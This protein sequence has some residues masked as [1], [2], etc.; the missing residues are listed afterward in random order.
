MNHKL[1]F[2]LIGSGTY[3]K[4]HAR[5]YKTDPR[6]TLKSLWSPT[7]SHREA[8]ASHFGCTA[9][10]NWNEIVEDSSINC[11]AIAT[12]DFAHTEYAVAALKAGKHVILEK[13]MALSAGECKKIIDARD[14]TSSKLMINYHNRWYPAFIA[15]R[16]AILSGRIGKPVS[17][18]FVL[19]DTISWVEDNMKWADG[20]GPEWFLMSHIADLAFWM[21][22]DNP[23]EIFAMS[24][25]GL[26]E[27]KGFKTR[28]LVKAIMRMKNGTVVHFESSWVLARNWRNPVNDMRVSVQCEQGR[29][30]IV[31]DYEN[32]TITSDSYKTPLIL[33]EQ[34]EVTPIQ[35]FITSV[36]QDKPVPVTGEEG[37]LTTKAIEAVVKSY[38]EKRIVLLDE[39]K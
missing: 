35:D 36:I 21:M 1:V 11:V 31:A 2:G 30:D 17:G 14:S 24:R 4:V 6:V 10:E 22:R 20:S 7:K 26:L 38:T 37:L 8:A 18:N 12:P 15:G 9:R 33:L 27:S 34:T 16:E 3:A 19:S 39:I 5:V 32:I 28:D 23:S 13:P 25:E 29:V